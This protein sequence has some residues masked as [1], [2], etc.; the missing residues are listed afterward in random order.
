MVANRSGEQEMTVAIFPLA[1]NIAGAY[2]LYLQSIR[3]AFRFSPQNS[4][5]R[6]PKLILTLKVWC[7]NINQKLISETA[8]HKSNTICRLLR[9]PQKLELQQSNL[10]ALK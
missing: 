4:A 8:G 1:I 3:Y 10:I 5:E 7:K 6:V 2:D 9:I